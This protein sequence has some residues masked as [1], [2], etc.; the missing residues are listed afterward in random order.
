MPQFDPSPQIRGLSIAL[1]L[2]IASAASTAVAQLVLGYGVAWPGFTDDD[3]DRMH[4]AAARLYEGQSSV[5][6]VERW[7]SPESNDAGEVTLVR[8]FDS[9]G[10]PCRTIDY[11]IH[12]AITK[13]SPDHY[14]INWC[15]VSGKTWKIVELAKPP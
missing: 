10:M 3:F 4:T 6:T 9:H 11:T 12:F 2:L 5:G 7:R 1:G 8:I 14:V 13:D 15:R